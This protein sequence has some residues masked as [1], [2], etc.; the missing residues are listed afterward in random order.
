MGIIIKGI[1]EKHTFLVY[2]FTIISLW[3][4]YANTMYI[5]A[6]ICVPQS[7]H[8]GAQYTAQYR[9]SDTVYNWKN[10]FFMYVKLTQ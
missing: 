6:V 9:L 2:I 5:C 4:T 7:C 8:I 3:R 1:D 10:T